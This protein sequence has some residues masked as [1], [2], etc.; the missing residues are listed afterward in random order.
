MEVSHSSEFE[1][2]H[3]LNNTPNGC[4][5]LIV[6]CLYIAY[7]ADVRPT[8]RGKKYNFY[9]R[10]MLRLTDALLNT[11]PAPASVLLQ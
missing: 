10:D 8:K 2:K 4:S 11:A 1:H 3:I 9:N 6:I 7:A 5:T